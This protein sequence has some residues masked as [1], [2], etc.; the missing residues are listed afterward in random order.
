M[1]F[2]LVLTTIAIAQNLG[3]ANTLLRQ[4]IEIT[5][6]M[7]FHSTGM[8]AENMLRIEAHDYTAN[9][10]TFRYMRCVF[11]NL[12]LWSDVNG[13]QDDR[14]KEILE[15]QTN[16]CEILN[17]VQKCN[18]SSKTNDEDVWLYNIL[19]CIGNGIAELGIEN[20]NEAIGK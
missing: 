16:R 11:E 6:N 1:K 4:E 5:S 3:W 17:L 15:D 10:E 2:F 7:C 20:N 13:I 9:Q 8:S 18:E 12:G 14:M 19:G